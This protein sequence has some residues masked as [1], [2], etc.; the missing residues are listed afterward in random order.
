[1]ERLI[2]DTTE[3]YT[4]MSGIVRVN[5]RKPFHIL[6]MDQMRGYTFRVRG[7]RFKWGYK[8]GDLNAERKYLESTV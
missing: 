8:K 1:M 5:F 6:E 4:F 2:G 7:K 3:V